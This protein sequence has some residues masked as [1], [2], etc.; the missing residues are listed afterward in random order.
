MLSRDLEQ[1]RESRGWGGDDAQGE[2]T[3]ESFCCV[4]K[5]ERFESMEDVGGGEARC[6]GGKKHFT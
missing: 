5:N 1:L 6:G 3:V 4:V 2:R